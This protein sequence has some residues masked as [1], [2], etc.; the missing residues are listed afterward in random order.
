MFFLKIHKLFIFAFN[1]FALIYI[2]LIFILIFGI[3]PLPQP[4]L[5]S[6]NL[7]YKGDSTPFPG[8]RGKNIVNLG[9][10]GRRG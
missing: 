7:V 9:V 4:K 5:D 2:A 10:D 6:W 1:V 8:C 3:L